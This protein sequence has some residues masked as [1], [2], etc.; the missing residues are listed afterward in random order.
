[1]ENLLYCAGAVRIARLITFLSIGFL[2]GL[3][4]PAALFGEAT[5]Q[6]E[7]SQ[8]DPAARNIL[9]HPDRPGITWIDFEHATLFSSRV[10]LGSLSAN[11]KRRLEVHD[12]AKF[13]KSEDSCA[14][15]ISRARAELARL[16]GSP[17]FRR[18]TG[19]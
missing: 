7:V 15:E 16:V 8:K 18:R 10:I 2:T 3:T 13:P 6:L 19:G 5:H 17:S 9:V 14:K 1:M 12:G 4:T 11:R